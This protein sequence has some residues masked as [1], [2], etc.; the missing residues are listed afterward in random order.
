[1]KN[2]TSLGQIIFQGRLY[3]V[4]QDFNSNGSGKTKVMLD[5]VVI[6][7]GFKFKKTSCKT[8][9]NYVGIFPEDWL[10]ISLMNDFVEF[11]NIGKVYT[12]KG[13]CYE[14]DRKDGSK[15]HGIRNVILHTL[16]K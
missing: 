7:E 4:S 2:T 1:M 10:D 9:K 16:G 15:S 6:I 12:F 5:P 8:G 13:E 11:G 3:S 14:Y